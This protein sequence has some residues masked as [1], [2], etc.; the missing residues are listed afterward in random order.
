MNT[1]ITVIPPKKTTVALKLD[2]EKEFDMIEHITIL[3]IL[4]A[5]GFGK[6]WCNWMKMIFSSGTSSVLLNGI[7]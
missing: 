1:C 4:E 3:E 2:F 7:P 6:I 5:K